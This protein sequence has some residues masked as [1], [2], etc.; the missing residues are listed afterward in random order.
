ME[1][2]IVNIV[3]KLGREGFYEKFDFKNE[4]K[5]NYEK[6]LSSEVNRILRKNTALD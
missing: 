3:T 4:G 1:K 6:P 2:S 5:Y